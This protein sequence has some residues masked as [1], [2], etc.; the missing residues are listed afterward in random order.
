MNAS[1]KQKLELILDKNCHNGKMKLTME[2]IERFE[3]EYNVLLPAG[4]KSFLKN[5]YS[6][7]VNDYYYFP[8]IEKSVLTQA[9][10]MEMIDYFYNLEFI[11]EVDNFISLY[12]KTVLPIGRSAGDYI[13][14][15]VS[16][17]NVGNIFFLYHEDVER[18]DGLYLVA[19][20]FEDF[21]LSFQH[22]EPKK[23]IIGKVE[24]NL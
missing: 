24:L 15:G 14:I 7:Y 22:I 23:R 19:D 12:G 4:Y 1:I 17:N 16:E 2:Q 11:S 9:N 3:Q 10:G 5:Y 21:I 18:E 6:C 20:S 8:M 13:C